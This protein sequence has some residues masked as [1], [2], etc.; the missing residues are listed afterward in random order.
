MPIP[1]SILL[2]HGLGGSGEGSVK[3]LEQHLV[4]LG[5]EGARFLRPTISA[6]NRP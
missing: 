5:W 3:L 2:L 1:S 4:N 6:V